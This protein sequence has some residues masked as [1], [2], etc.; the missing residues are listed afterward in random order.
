MIIIPLNAIHIIFCALFAAIS[1]QLLKPI[2]GYILDP[3]KKWNWRLAIDAGGF[4]SSHSAMVTALA[5]AVGIH[6]HFSSTL[7]AITVVLAIIVIY[8]AA[9][10]RYY[11]GQNIK[12]T[13]QLVRDLQDKYPKTFNNPIYDTKLKPIL[14]HRWIEVLGGILWGVVIAYI[15]HLVK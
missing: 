9:N 11:S 14:G 15:F 3:N 8:D 5:I 6:E 10:V 13:Q 4:P 2:R 1:A 12:V 7:F